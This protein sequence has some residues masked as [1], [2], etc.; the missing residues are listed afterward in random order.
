MPKKKTEPDKPT[1]QRQD[2]EVLFEGT[3]A[4][5]RAEKV[6]VAKLNSFLNAPLG[7]KLWSA[8]SNARPKGRSPQNVGISSDELIGYISGYEACL[9]LIRAMA[10]IDES[11]P[12]I[13]ST[14]E[15]STN[16]TDADEQ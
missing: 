8:L 7:R 16:E 2:R 6:D 1:Q 5:F 14:W 9:G 10:T 12:E 13:P 4:A 3:I 15:D 11:T